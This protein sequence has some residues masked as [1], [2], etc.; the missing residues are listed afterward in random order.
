MWHQQAL[1]EGVHEL[2]RCNTKE[3]PADL[4][5]K[6]LERQTIDEHRQ[7]ILLLSLEEAGFSVEGE[8]AALLFSV[9]A[10]REKV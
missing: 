5:T 4:G 1:R 7:R 10:A 9:V 8:L 3:N 2:V 6:P